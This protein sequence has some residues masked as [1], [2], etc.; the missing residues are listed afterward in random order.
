MI[1]ILFKQSN[2]VIY[3]SCRALI[4]LKLCKNKKNKIE[5]NGQLVYKGRN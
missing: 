5:C 1:K 2:S 3:L 4:R